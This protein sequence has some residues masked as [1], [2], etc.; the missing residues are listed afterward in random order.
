[1]KLKG[2]LFDKTGK[3]VA[4]STGFCGITIT[5]EEVK[6][7]AYDSLKSSFGFLAVG[8]RDPSPPSRVFPLPSFFSH[9]LKGPPSIRWRSSKPQK[10]SRVRDIL[11]PS[12]GIP[13]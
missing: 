6:K 9:P 2:S 3:V 4:T 8:K 7:S 11:P 10:L 1:M 5:D 13:Q 12:R